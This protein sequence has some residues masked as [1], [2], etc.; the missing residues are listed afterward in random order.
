MNKLQK[1]IKSLE[2]NYKVNVSEV[3]NLY[4]QAWSVADIAEN[5][6]V[7][8]Y[9]IS[10]ILK[11][12][13]LKRP[14]NK[15]AICI[16]E[17]YAMLNEESLDEYTEELED[18]NEILFNKVDKLETQLI[19]TRAELNVK[20]KSQRDLVK[21][22]IIAE[23]LLSSLD[24]ALKNK[25]LTKVKV[26]VNKTQD[27]ETNEGLVVVL[28]DQHIGE[29]VGPDIVQNTYNYNE[30]LKRLDKFI[31]NILMFPRQSKKITVVQCGDM[32]R[33][34]IHGGIYNSEDSFIDSINKAVDYNV[35]LYNILAEVYEEVNIYSITGNHDRVT[36]DPKT[37]SKALDFTR[38]VDSMVSRQL[39]ALKVQNVNLY[40]TPAPYH[41]VNINSA[42]VLMFH[43]D[44]VR[45]YNAADA[46]QRSLI[47]DL[48][49]GTFKKPYTH[50]ISGHSHSFMACHNQYGGM[51]IVNGTLVGSNAFG[52]ANGMRDICASQTICYID[53][54]GNLELVQAVKLN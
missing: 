38:L 52:V 32:L 27:A 4:E 5:Q 48:C 37:E 39:R 19:K 6:R 49:L 31:G 2:D 1:L 15:R 9:V 33:G 36:E 28:S 16:K 43:G 42:N 17:H 18:E 10:N 24:K 30:A 47:Q 50:A 3:V 45:K 12:L 54:E 14:K 11:H 26:Q 13:Q 34:L 35:Y 40:I 7:T 53:T 29:L 20:R 41:L 23:K 46:N 25:P 8:P 51:N 22:E 21:S 44:T